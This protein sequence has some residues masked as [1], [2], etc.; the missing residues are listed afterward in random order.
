MSALELIRGFRF[1][2]TT[3]ILK[4]SYGLTIQLYGFE[5]HRQRSHPQTTRTIECS[6]DSHGLLGFAVTGDIYEFVQIALEMAIFAE[7][8][9]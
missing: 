5:K 1:R 4:A 6:I 8:D 7:W 2:E 3:K 9:W